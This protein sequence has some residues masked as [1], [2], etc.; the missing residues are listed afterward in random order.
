M[1]QT[2]LWSVIAQTEISDPIFEP[3]MI[4]SESNRGISFVSPGK[5][6]KTQLSSGEN[7]QKLR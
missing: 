1:E 2:L 7:L 6:I 5:V 3:V 4:G